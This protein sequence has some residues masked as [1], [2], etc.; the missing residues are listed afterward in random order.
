MALAWCRLGDKTYCLLQVSSQGTILHASQDLL[1]SIS[2]HILNICLRVLCRSYYFYYMYIFKMGKTSKEKESQPNYCK[3][4]KPQWN[5]IFFDDLWILGL[6]KNNLNQLVILLSSSFIVSSKSLMSPCGKKRFV[7]F[8]KMVEFSTFE[9]WCRSF[10]YNSINKGP[11][12]DPWGR[13]HAFVALL[14]E[15]RSKEINYF[16]FFK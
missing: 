2:K 15:L 14:V 7:S 3:I 5:I 11:N 6:V 13:S 9:E 8:V 1:I 10:K 4:R 16:W 12:I